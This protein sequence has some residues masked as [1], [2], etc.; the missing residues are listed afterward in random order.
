MY[1]TLPDETRMMGQTGIRLSFLYIT[2]LQKYTEKVAAEEAQSLTDQLYKSYE[3]VETSKEEVR[4]AARQAIGLE[5]PVQ[6]AVIDALAI[7]MFPGL[8]PACGM[9]PALGMA[10]LIDQ[11]VVVTTEGDLSTAVAGILLRSL[12][13][14][15]C[16]LGEHL[17]FD[18][19]E[20]FIL[21]GHEGGSAGFSMAKEG[22]RPKLRNTQFV[23]FYRVPGAPHFGVLPEFITHPGPVPL[24]TFFPRSG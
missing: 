23:N 2:D 22:T 16:Y 7:D 18:E 12:T 5:R 11:G 17:V 1:D 9:L 10:R 24:V 19:K 13:G 20:N 8:M 14:K 15:P 6:D 4:L 3:V 21:G